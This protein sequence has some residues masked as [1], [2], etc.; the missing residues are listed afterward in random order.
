M[1]LVTL[2]RSRVDRCLGP[3]YCSILLIIYG[4]WESN[5]PETL[6]RYGS[7]CAYDV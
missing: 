3:S 5:I 7:L 2:L 6:M 4:L 1:V